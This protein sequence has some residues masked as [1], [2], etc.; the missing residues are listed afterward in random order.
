MKKALPIGVMDYHKLI[1][2]NYYNVDKSL[3]IKDFLEIKTTVTLIT[4]PRRFGNTLNMSIQR[5]FR[6]NMLHT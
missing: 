3:M 1:S 4:R 2:E 6:K 5:L